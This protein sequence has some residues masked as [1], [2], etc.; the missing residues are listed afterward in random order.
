MKKPG[1]FDLRSKSQFEKH[2]KE[3]TLI[4]KELMQVY[5]NWLNAKR[6][7]G[8]PEYTFI[9]H[10]VDNTG[11][12]IERSC[13]VD[14]SADFILRRLGRQDKKIDIKFC[15]PEHKIFHLKVSQMLEYIQEDVC[16]INFMGIDG[17]NPRFCILTPGALAQWL[18]L[19]ERIKFRPWGG[20]EVIR[21]HNSDFEWHKVQL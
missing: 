12:L 5:V 10:G 13:D 4:E 9:D 3:C 7:T 16:I 14:M 17:K 8:S 11:K 1:R 21:F 15:R 19:G 20:K 18:D 6:S 2:I